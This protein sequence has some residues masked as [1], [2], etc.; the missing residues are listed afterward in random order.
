MRFCY[1]IVLWRFFLR[2]SVHA[3]IYWEIEDFLT[4][5]LSNLLIIQDL[6]SFFKTRSPPVYLKIHLFDD[7]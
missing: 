7:P 3:P 6:T 1:F 4:I 2:K 5:K